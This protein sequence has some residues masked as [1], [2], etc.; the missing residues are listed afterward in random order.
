MDEA[1]QRGVQRG[2]GDEQVRPGAGLGLDLLPLGLVLREGDEPADDRRGRVGELVLAHGLAAVEDVA[3]DRMAQVGHVD[4]DLVGAPGLEL[5]L[6]QGVAA[7]LLAHAEERQG[8]PARGVVAD[9][10]GLADG[11]VLADGLVDRA[12]G[13]VEV[14]VDDGEVGLERRAVLELAGDAPVGLLALG[15][16]DDAGGVLVE[17]VDDAGAELAGPDGGEAGDAPV[18]AVGVGLAGGGIGCG[19]WLGFWRRYRRCGRRGL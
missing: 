9:A 17:P 10:A 18:A 2:V 11:G 13:E 14:A 1:Q 7:V 12:A 5:E 19:A 15:D 16:D 6:D 4:A 8:V 3:Y